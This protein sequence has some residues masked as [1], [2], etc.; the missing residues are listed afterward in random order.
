MKVIGILITAILCFSFYY[1]AKPPE[2]TMEEILKKATFKKEIF[3]DFK[4]Y[5]AIGNILSLNIDTIL[6][7]AKKTKFDEVIPFH[8]F[9]HDAAPQNMNI[10]G[11][12]FFIYKVVDS[13][14]NKIGQDNILE[15]IINDDKSVIINAYYYRRSDTIAED[16]QLIWNIKSG[17]NNNSFDLYK[18]TIFK[19][20]TYRI[21]VAKD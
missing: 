3:E 9:S 5:E 12:P 11:L 18:D 15:L 13:L 6:R 1:T 14:W 7:K 20:C 21:G 8:S 17:D 19:N 16:H 10:K 4:N 2:D